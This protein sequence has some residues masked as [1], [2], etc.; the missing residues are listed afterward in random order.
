MKKRRT[1][2]VVALL[3]LLALAAGGGYWAWKRGKG[4][5]PPQPAPAPPPVV[6]LY[7][8]LPDQI[9]P[10]DGAVVQGTEAWVRWS[11]SAAAKGTVLWRKAGETDFRQVEAAEGDPRLARLAGLKPGE[12][13]EYCV[14]AVGEG[15]ARRSDLRK[16]SVQEGLAFE[17]VSDYAVRRD[18]DQTIRLTLRNRADKPATIAAKALVRFDDLPADVVGP[19]SV[20]EPVEVPPGG[21]TDLR[22]VVTAA[23][24][25]Q[26]AYEIP[27]EG[28]GAFTAARVRIA[29]PDFKLAFRVVGE[30]PRTLAKTVEVRN[31]GAALADLAVNVAEPNR[32][33]VRLEPAASHAY[34][35]AGNTLQF[36]AAPVLYLG[37]ASLR[38]EL[39]FRAAGQAGRF[40]LEFTAPAGKR[41]IGVRAGTGYT[42][43]ASDWYCTN[44]PAT[45]GDVPAAPGNGPMLPAA[46][47]VIAPRPGSCRS[48]VKCPKDSDAPC[49]N[50]KG[51][52]GFDKGVTGPGDFDSEQD[53][54]VAVLKLIN[55][56]S[57]ANCVEFSGHIYQDPETGKFHWT[58]DCEGNDQCVKVTNCPSRMK[59]TAVW[60]T[61][62]CDPPGKPKNHGFS[63]DDRNDRDWTHNEYLATPSGDVL[64][65]PITK[66]KPPGPGTGT[67]PASVLTDKNGKIITA[68]ATSQK[69]APAPAGGSTRP[70]GET[71]PQEPA[72]EASAAPQLRLGLL[73]AVQRRASFTRT[74]RGP[75]AAPLDGSAA[76]SADAAAA[77]HAGD[78]VCFAWHQDGLVLFA[79]FDPAG[80]T[81]A[82]PQ[83][84]GEGRWPRLAVDGER[85]AVA[86]SRGDGFVVRLLDDAKWGGEIALT[87][88]EAAVAFAPGGPLFAA[89]S[90][91]LWKLS[92]K[93]FERLTDTAYAQPS[94]AVDPQGRPHVAWRKGG[95][96]ACDDVEVAEGERPSLLAA[97]DGVLHL[98]YLSNGSLALRSR[99]ERGWGAVEAL[100]A[101]N[102]SWPALAQGDDGVRLT[103]LGPADH[104]PDALWLV[105]LRDKKPLLVPSLAGNVTD[106]NLI[107]HFGLTSERWY[108]RPHDLWLFANDIPV[109]GFSHA[110]PEGR[111]LFPLNPHQVFTSAGRPETNRVAIR[112]WHDNSGHYKVASDYQIVTRTAWSEWFA[113]AADEAEVRKAAEGPGVNH[114]KP[115]LAVLANAL[116]LPAEPPKDGR[117][118]FA[119]VVANLGEA[120]S[121]SARLVM[122][123]EGKT[124]AQA[125]I[126]PMPPGERVTATMRL[127]GRVPSIA[128]KLEQDRPDFNPDNDTLTLHL[129]SDQDP[130]LAKNPTASVVQAPTADF[131]QPRG[132]D[133]KAWKPQ[134]VDRSNPDWMLSADGKAV[135]Q[136]NDFGF[137]R[138]P[139][140][141]F[142]VSP[143]EH[144]DATLKCL[145]RR[146]AD[147]DPILG[148]EIGLVFGYK[149]PLAE[150]GDKDDA[151]EFLLFQW[152]SPGFSLFRVK[153]DKQESLAPLVKDDWK[154]GQDYA[155]EVRYEKDRIRIGRDGK[156]LFDV[157]GTFPAGRFGFYNVRLA[158]TRYSGATI[159]DFSS[160]GIGVTR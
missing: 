99:K 42:N 50:P 124:L 160:H 112:S 110:I 56:I 77:Y 150:K 33:D 46:G 63:P 107:V 78:R 54:A 101:R 130:A 15:A 151:D 118:D 93:G 159:V 146:E 4:N 121:A 106:A 24:A 61:H 117:T 136:T 103:Y 79:A 38:A 58:I 111:Y 89:T 129:W 139:P 17:A 53:A 75:F 20:D 123:H 104:G 148:G 91:G 3:L 102:P 157:K 19:G 120:A 18:Y 8:P 64:K 109:G 66:D 52:T 144:D 114:D 12:T 49:D 22:L 7:A 85:T 149:S 94:L 16:F 97:A 28:A 43:S 47:P 51:K 74:H 45:C 145:I 69:A 87:G 98:A 14:E 39:E 70:C 153:G 55:P 27:V 155:F 86:W 100:P 96:V 142:F 131:G 147:P 113:Y 156:P 13:Y 132:Q 134:G 23:D 138:H 29:P 133:L 125:A 2:L 31:D 62:A 25:T 82:E 67:G 5:G 135:V 1:L 116:D 65:Y 34:L 152:A 76:D 108:Y 90:T 81:V 36:T 83:A 88:K 154:T 26:E 105:R 68:P 126:P 59:C 84:I 143:D 115:D 140:L 122:L 41:L 158:N 10:A 119:V 137:N 141:L 11:P 95:K 6:K 57:V 72:G 92:G 40:P 73:E 44:K 80:E 127:D 37:F 30:D 32:R 60:H 48:Q 21:K 128:F 71:V 35:P 9:E